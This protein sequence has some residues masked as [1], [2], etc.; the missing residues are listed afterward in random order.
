MLERSSATAPTDVACEM[1]LLDPDSQERESLARER[2]KI[3]PH[4]VIKRRGVRSVF[5]QAMQDSNLAV[6][7]SLTTAKRY[8]VQTLNREPLRVRG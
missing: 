4:G 1:G 6:A 3:Q 2:S 8:C 7:C 5:Q